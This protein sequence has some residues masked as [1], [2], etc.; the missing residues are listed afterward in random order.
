[1][2]LSKKEIVEKNCEIIFFSNLDVGFEYEPKS[3]LT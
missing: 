3:I 2:I 1:M